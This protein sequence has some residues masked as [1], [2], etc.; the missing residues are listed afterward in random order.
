M[1]RIICAWVLVS[2][3][4]ATEF[5]SL[6]EVKT[7]A[8]PDSG[9]VEE[10][11]FSPTDEQQAAVQAKAKSSARGTLA[12]IFL[13]HS[14]GKL[15]GVAFI[16]NVIGRT[17]P[18]TF[19]CVIGA[20][21][22]VRRLDVM[23]FREPI[24]GQVRDERFLKQYA[25][26]G[27]EDPV[28]RGRDIANIGG[29]TMSV[30]ALTERVRYFLALY[31]LVLKDQVTVRLK[32][33]PQAQA[34]TSN[35]AIDI[36]EGAAAIGNSS[37]TI[38]IKHDGSD[39]SR[40]RAQRAI[41]Q[42]IRRA[43]DLDAVVNSWRPDSELSRLN[44]EGRIDASA[45]LLAAVQTAR[46]FWDMTGGLFD[47]SVGPLISAWKKAEDEQ[48]LLT[49]TKVDDLR[50]ATGFS[51]VVVDQ[52]DITLPKGGA[53]DLGGMNKGFIV[54]RC[55]EAMQANLHPEDS[56]MV[57][58]GDSSMRAHGTPS[59]TLHAV[60]IRDPAD[61]RRIAQTLIL[62][63]GQGFGYSSG[64]G[65]T[66]SVNGTTYSHLINPIT[67]QPGPLD[68]AAAVIGP[69]AALADGLDTALC[70]MDTQTALQFLAKHPE[71]QALLWDGS[72]THHSAGWPGVAAEP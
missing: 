14:G 58:F 46:E 49:G 12:K 29:A 67:G 69:S 25:G 59:V 2:A 17:E 52:T 39:L 70:L 28:R 21:G 26:K 33:Q 13:G 53:L 6:D 47:P 43:Q 1:L 35:V 24:G 65:R 9:T 20:D 27:P 48:R 11:P 37:L 63:P 41:D 23:V 42:A 34:E 3:L 66:F 50:A 64:I 71:I 68:R 18:I 44:D 4:P 72:L 62:K 57:R 54:D 19:S 5:L 61:P 36:S 38:S 31:D 45:S 32:A 10:F 16:D 60:E 8:F 40:D 56:A 7:L 51:Q 15:D 55:A 22:R 30:D